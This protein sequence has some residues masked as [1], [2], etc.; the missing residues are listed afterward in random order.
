MLRGGLGKYSNQWPHQLT[1]R[2][3]R[4]E[5]GVEGRERR[6]SATKV[7]IGGGKQVQNVRRDAETVG[8]EK[9][10]CGQYC[11][12]ICTWCHSK[13]CPLQCKAS[14]QSGYRCTLTSQHVIKY[15]HLLR[16]VASISKAKRRLF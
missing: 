11:K 16:T 15:V 4:R 9:G 1:G 2:E 10:R 12:Q 8:K 6:G 3:E 14:A 13:S 7:Q 5:G